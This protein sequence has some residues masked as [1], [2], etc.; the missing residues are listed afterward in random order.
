MIRYGVVCLIFLIGGHNPTMNAAPASKPEEELEGI[1]IVTSHSWCG[2]EM[3]LKND[4]ESKMYFRFSGHTFQHKLGVDIDSTMEGTYRKVAY[5]SPKH[6]D[7]TYTKGNI[8][9]TKRRIYSLE[10]D[11]L[12]IAFTLTFAPGTP[13]DELKEAKRIFAIRPKSFDSKP[14]ELTFILVLH[15]QRK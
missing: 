13:E 12:K 3:P 4:V 6:L 8:L 14:E 10:G 15:R 11:Q 7:L 5:K 9:A 1:W 2:K